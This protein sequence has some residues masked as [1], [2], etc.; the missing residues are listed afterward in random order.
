MKIRLLLLTLSC[1]LVSLPSVQAQAPAPK[2]QFETPL[3]DN[4]AKMNDA[5]RTLRGQVADAT[6]NA[7][8]AKLAATIK[9]TA[10]ASLKLEPAKKADIPAAD[11]AKF[12]SS[13]KE[14]MQM[15]VDQA[16]K[17]ESALKAGDNTAAAKLLDD[18]GAHQKA[19]HKEYKQQKKKKDA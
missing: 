5:L 3:G 6:K 7:D 10:T 12:V 11:Q 19:S 18:M 16:G 8:S 17:L 14:A 4:M 9:E 13:Y 15:L 2:R 1:A